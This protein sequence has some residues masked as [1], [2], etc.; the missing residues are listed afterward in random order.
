MISPVIHECILSGFFLCIEYQLTSREKS[1]Q[2]YKGI[3][4]MHYQYKIIFWLT[5]LQ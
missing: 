2:E 4:E 3:L 1:L 5:V